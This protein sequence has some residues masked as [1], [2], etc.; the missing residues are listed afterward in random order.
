MKCPNWISDVM[1]MTQKF[2]ILSLSSWAFLIVSCTE[3]QEPLDQSI[4]FPPN[5]SVT[6]ETQSVNELGWDET[7]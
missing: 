5:G 3:A 2:K 7:C 6:W 4:Y 1:T